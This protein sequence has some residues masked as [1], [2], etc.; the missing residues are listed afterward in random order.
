M[1]QFLRRLGCIC[2]SGRLLLS[3]PSFRFESSNVVVIPILVPLLPCSLA[4]L[5]TFALIDLKAGGENT[6]SMGKKQD[7][8]ALRYVISQ[9]LRVNLG[10]VLE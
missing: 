7:I 1:Y 2:S 8:R 6:R 10:Q 3:K 5:A 9:D 4:G